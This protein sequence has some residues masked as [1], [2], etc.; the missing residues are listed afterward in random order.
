M[1]RSKYSEVVQAGMDILDENVPGWESR[2]N[3]ETLNLES[4]NFCVLGQI[5]G[6]YDV[7]KRALGVQN[8][9]ACGFEVE[10]GD[11]RHYALLTRAWLRVI[12]KRFTSKLS[13][14]KGRFK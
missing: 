14:I 11:S 1:S 7:G 13:Q 8:T 10:S 6:G 3:P 4:C 5:Y 2:I 12:Q 9:D